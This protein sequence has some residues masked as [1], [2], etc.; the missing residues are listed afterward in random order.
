MENGKPEGKAFGFHN[1]SPD[2]VKFLQNYAEIIF[3]MDAWKESR[4]SCC[5]FCAFL[6]LKLHIC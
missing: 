4:R 2:K 3:S 1:K 6:R 5:V